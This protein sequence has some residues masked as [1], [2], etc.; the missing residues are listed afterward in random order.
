MASSI[1]GEHVNPQVMVLWYFPIIRIMPKYQTTFVLIVVCSGGSWGRRGE[2]KIEKFQESLTNIKFQD[3]QSQGRGKEWLVERMDLC[4]FKL[5]LTKS[6]PGSCG[7][8]LSFKFF[9]SSCWGLCD[10][11]PALLFISSCCFSA[12]SELSIWQ[13]FQHIYI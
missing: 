3:Q 7:N 4:I 5:L 9:I 2:K 8:G 6:A 12:C 13:V 10:W 1:K 11:N